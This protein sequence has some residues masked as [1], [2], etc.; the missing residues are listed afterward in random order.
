MRSEV[1]LIAVTCRHC[2]CI[3]QTVIDYILR[4]TESTAQLG[5]IQ[6]TRT[7]VL[8]EPSSLRPQGPRCPE[9][10]PATRF[11]SRAFLMDS[12]VHPCRCSSR[13]HG[14]LSQSDVHL[15]AL[16][17]IGARRQFA[18]SG[19]SRATDLGRSWKQDVRGRANQL[20]RILGSIAISGDARHEE[21][22]EW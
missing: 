9:A 8:K 4:S 3:Q 19:G 21:P 22:L 10:E 1:G 2:T 14:V 7:P 17:V 20:V 16:K 18:R 6:G 5:G 13:F 12:E 11:W 15:V